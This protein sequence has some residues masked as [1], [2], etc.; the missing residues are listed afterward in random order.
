MDVHGVLRRLAHGGGS[1][2]DHTH[3]DGMLIVGRQAEI[4]DRV[5]GVALGWL[6]RS[7]ADRVTTDL[8]RGAEVVDVGTGPGRLLVDL[9]RLR[10]DAHVVG[11]DPSADMVEHALRRARA[12][13]VSGHVE[14]RVA[15]AESLPFPDAS[16]DLV[17]SSLSAHHWADA[18]V[19]VAEQARVLRAGGQ[20]WIVDLRGASSPAVLESLRASFPADAMTQP[21]L[22]LLESSLFVCHR[23]VRP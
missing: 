5:S 9:A 15:S 17:V 10:P 14:A 1:A 22:G 16:V 2:G 3:A 7:V 13:G 18:S 21:R 4:Y 11:I 12:A 19:A 6:Y 20:L 23:A 8:P